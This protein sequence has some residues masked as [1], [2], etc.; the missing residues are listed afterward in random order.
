MVDPPEPLGP[1][2]SAQQSP[3]GRRLVGGGFSFASRSLTSHSH[4][5]CCISKQGIACPKTFLSYQGIVQ[6]ALTHARQHTTNENATED[7]H[8][9]HPLREAIIRQIKEFF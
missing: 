8:Y 3:L 2:W 7:L 1:L 5:K 9:P 6:A 4:L